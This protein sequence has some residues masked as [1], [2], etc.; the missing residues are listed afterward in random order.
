MVRLPREK[1]PTG[2]YHIML[3]GIDGR[4]I[5]MTDNDKGRFMEILVKG[6]SVSGF[7][8][9]GY[10]LM[11]N[12]VH[13]LIKEGEDIGTCMKRMTVSYAIWHNK[14]HG[15][16]GHLFQNRYRSEVVDNEIYLK[17]VLRYIHRNPVKANIV[18]QPGDYTWS[19]YND[20]IQ[21]YNGENGFVDGELI[22]SLYPE[23]SQFKMFMEEEIEDYCMD[24]ENNLNYSDDDIRKMI[25]RDYHINPNKI[26]QLPRQERAKVLMKLYQEAGISIRQISRI[27]GLSKSMVGS[28]IKKHITS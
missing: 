15:R 2:V 6:K 20:Y 11:D 5:L 18:L 23:K 24:Y 17:T 14:R 16:T 4:N 8:L 22:K 9:L 27:A 25:I 12:H 19:S 3:R 28:E 21:M 10:C 1:S 13:I 26:K 7:R